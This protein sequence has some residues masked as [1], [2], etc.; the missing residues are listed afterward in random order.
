MDRQDNGHD[1]RTAEVNEHAPAQQFFRT[2]VRSGKHHDAAGHDQAE[3]ADYGS[4]GGKF[5]AGVIEA[6][7]GQ[8]GIHAHAAHDLFAYGKTQSLAHAPRHVGSR[9]KGSDFLHERQSFLASPQNDEDETQRDPCHADG[10]MRAE[11]RI[12]TAE[13]GRPCG[14]PPFAHGAHF[15]IDQK[16]ETRKEQKKPAHGIAP[17]QK[18][19][20]DG[21]TADHA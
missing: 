20:P 5:L 1:A 10:Y 14:C 17:V 3:T 19:T 15:R 12:Q 6:L 4:N 16:G 13:Q 9:M 18:N 11:Q 7:R 8:R 21:V 2:R